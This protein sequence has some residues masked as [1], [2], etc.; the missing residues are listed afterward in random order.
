MIKNNGEKK[1]MKRKRKK[2]KNKPFGA[3]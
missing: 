2:Q 3:Q 1:E